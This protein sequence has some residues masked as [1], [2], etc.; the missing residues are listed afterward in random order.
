MLS[1]ITPAQTPT[2]TSFFASFARSAVSALPLTALD[3]QLVMY[4]SCPECGLPLPLYPHTHCR[5][6][7]DE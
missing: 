2:P 7:G 6:E 1:S 3:G 5:E 4:L